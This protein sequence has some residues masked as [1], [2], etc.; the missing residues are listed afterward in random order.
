MLLLL[1][2]FVGKKP[3]LHELASAFLKSKQDSQGVWFGTVTHQGTLS[4]QPFWRPESE[5]GMNPLAA[6]SLRSVGLKF[7]SRCPVFCG[8]TLCVPAFEAGGV[9]TCP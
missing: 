2:N 8:C 6:C 5:E 4:R 9:Q 3:K 7:K 1:R